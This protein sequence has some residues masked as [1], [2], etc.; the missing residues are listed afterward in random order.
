MLVAIEN[1]VTTST[2]WSGNGI[3]ELVIISSA[4][5][6]HSPHSLRTTENRLIGRIDN[7][8]DACQYVMGYEINK[9]INFC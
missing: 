2:I 9:S 4:T 3:E 6:S 8:S 1:L 7:G 5:P